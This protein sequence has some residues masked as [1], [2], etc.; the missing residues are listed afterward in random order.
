MALP[1]EIAVGI[2]DGRLAVPMIPGARETGNLITF[3]QHSVLILA[4]GPSTMDAA[5]IAMHQKEGGGGPAQRRRVRQQSPWN[6]WAR[7]LR[8]SL[9]RWY[10]T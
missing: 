10:R 8:D 4:Q 7:K 9:V 5:T 1:E 6:A 3:G 2:R